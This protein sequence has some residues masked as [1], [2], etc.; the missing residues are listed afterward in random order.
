MK[1]YWWW[2]F[3]QWFEF[4]YQQL[5]FEEMQKWVLE[6]QVWVGC[7]EVVLVE[8]VDVWCFV[9]L[10][11]NLQVLCGIRLVSVVMLVVEVGDFICF[12]NFKQL[13]VY[14]GL[15]LFEYFSGVRIKW[16]WIICVGNVQVWMML[17][18]VGWLY[19]LFVCEE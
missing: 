5:V 2:L 1:M 3:E 10:V 15:V 7:L 16:G 4:F 18:E 14:V 9:L 8:V 6:V 11:C 19:W 13:M 17:I 12:D